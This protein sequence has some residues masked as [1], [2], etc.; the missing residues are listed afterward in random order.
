M[1]EYWV[2]D[3]RKWVEREAGDWGATETEVMEGIRYAGRPRLTQVRGVRKDG[4]YHVGRL[5]DTRAVTVVGDKSE[6]TVE[7][8]E[9]AKRS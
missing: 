5:E 2:I 4:Q 3:E 7:A 8:A 6:E 1:A 9:S